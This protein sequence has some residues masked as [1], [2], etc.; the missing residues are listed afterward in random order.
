MTPTC[1]QNFSHIF[2]VVKKPLKILPNSITT[3]TL[4]LRIRFAKCVI[5]EM[6]FT[7]CNNFH[8]W[9]GINKNNPQRLVSIHEICC[10]VNFC[11]LRRKHNK[12][13]ILNC[14]YFGVPVIWWCHSRTCDVASKA[15]SLSGSGWWERKKNR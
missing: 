3:I 5:T 2:N 15:F 7:L 1:L 10:A 12:V 13:T 9:N 6:Y 14:W 8:V 4:L 11:F